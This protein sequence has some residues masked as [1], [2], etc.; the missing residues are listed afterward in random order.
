MITPFTANGPPCPCR[1]KATFTA[2]AAIVAGGCNPAVDLD[3]HDLCLWL[4]KQ[5]ALFECTPRGLYVTGV[6]LSDHEFDLV[7]RHRQMLERWTIAAIVQRELGVSVDV[8]WWSPALLPRSER[9]GDRPTDAWQVI[10]RDLVA[11]TPELEGLW[12]LLYDH[13]PRL[14]RT[15][16]RAMHG[17]LESWKQHAT[18]TRRRRRFGTLP[19]TRKGVAGN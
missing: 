10:P 3:A 5:N 12:A 4:G 11:P 6:V 2:V 15:P 14:Y 17:F 16:W 9:I 1:G 13:G 18:T 7:I 19:L 8:V